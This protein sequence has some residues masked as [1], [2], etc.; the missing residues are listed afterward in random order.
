VPTNPTTLNIAPIQSTSPEDD[1][2]LQAIEA[3]EAITVDLHPKPLQ[4]ATPPVT[5]PASVVA[6]P[7]LIKQVMGP[8]VQRTPAAAPVTQP[9]P[10]A[11]VPI[12]TPVTHTDKPPQPPLP[13]KHRP[14][15]PAEAIAEE[16]ANAPP[17]SAKDSLFQ[18]FLRQLPSKKRLVAAIVI[19][20]SVVVLATAAYFVL[21]LA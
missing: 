7:P 8:V 15:T 13:P 16:L 2:T 3:L 4:P 18:P 14:S 11:P 17:T 19:G 1:A 12:P 10:A 5:Q 21:R 20:S 6:T 9:A